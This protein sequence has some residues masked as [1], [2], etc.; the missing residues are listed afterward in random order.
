MSK[1]DLREFQQQI[2]ERLNDPAAAARAAGHLGFVAGNVSWLVDVA[3]LKEVISPPPIAAV[4]LVQ[5][6]F[7]G[8]ANVRGELYCITDLAAFLLQT[9][10]V[11]DIHNRVLLIHDALV[12]STGLL[13]SR[14]L[15]LRDFSRCRRLDAVPAASWIAGHYE[16][17]AGVTWR[18]LDVRR[19][20]GEATFM[21]VAA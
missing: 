12:R 4:S 20:V 3:C 14:V 17:E 21:D 13:V 6:W 2:L 15:G 9:S 19:L 10:T 7:T 8:V 11:R 1:T 16:D 18:L 5:P